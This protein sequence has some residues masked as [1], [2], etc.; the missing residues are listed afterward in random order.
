MA[1]HEFCEAILIV[2]KSC[3]VQIQVQALT[4]GWVTGPG[5]GV[6][7]YEKKCGIYQS[8]LDN[9]KILALLC[10]CQVQI[11]DLGLNLKIEHLRKH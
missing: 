8:R 9:E 4:S 3:T 5:V 10:L 7:S 6:G 1:C 11:V 2:P